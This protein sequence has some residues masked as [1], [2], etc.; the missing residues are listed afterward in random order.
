[1]D[2]LQPLDRTGSVSHSNSN[3]PEV[4]RRFYNIVVDVNKIVPFPYPQDELISWCNTVDRLKPDLPLN[5]LRVAIDELMMGE[6]I[7]YDR[8]IGI[9]NVFDALRRVE[10]DE[11][12]PLG[13]KMTV[14]R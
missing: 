13:F 7:K 14:M 6:K 3:L 5:K 9:Q 11:S 2:K 8:N 12:A 1:M 10:V 4:I